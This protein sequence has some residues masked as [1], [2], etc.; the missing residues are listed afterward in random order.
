MKITT[1]IKQH[2]DTHPNG[3]RIYAYTE[4]ITDRDNCDPATLAD[5][6]A[7]KVEAASLD[8]DVRQRAREIMSR[9]HQIACEIND[10]NEALYIRECI[11]EAV[12]ARRGQK[13]QPK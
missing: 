6:H 9:Y 8:A 10:E 4:I 2:K 3:V 11:A 13:G 12:A 1:T 5:I 7:A